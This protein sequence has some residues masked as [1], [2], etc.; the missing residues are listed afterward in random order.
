MLLGYWLLIAAARGDLGEQFTERYLYLGA[1]LVLLVLL[2]LGRG[3]RLP[4][5]ALPLAAIGLALVTLTNVGLLQRDATG[6]GDRS[7]EVAVTVAALEVAGDHADPRFVPSAMVYGRNAEQI[8][9]ALGDLGSPY[10]GAREIRRRPAQLAGL[11]DAT[12][13]QAEGVALQPGL[14][15]A[16]CA[17]VP[18]SGELELPPGGRL[19]LRARGERVGVSLRRYAAGFPLEPSARLEP[20]QLGRLE[21]PRDGD[22]AT[23]WRVRLAPASAAQRCGG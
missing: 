20:G 14:P 1:L 5:R 21:A 2:E 3:A 6:I 22:P 15:T 9:E 23:P 17:P 12:L 18:A 7:N 11:A 10:D 8:L 19:D 4:R 13:A 16:G